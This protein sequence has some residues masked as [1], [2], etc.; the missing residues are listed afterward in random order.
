MKSGKRHKQTAPRRKVRFPISAKILLCLGLNIAV[1]ALVFGW[2][3]RSHFG[4]EQDWL[5]NNTARERLQAMNLVLIAELRESPLEDWDEIIRKAGDAHRVKL[6]LFEKSGFHVAGC[7]VTLPPELSER[8][9]GHGTPGRSQPRKSR[10]RKQASD[11]GTGVFR[12]FGF[13][14]DEQKAELER[15]HWD[16]VERV[17][18]IFE[19]SEEGRDYLENG[20]RQWDPDPDRKRRFI[21]DTLA[22]TRSERYGPANYIKEAV[23]SKD[24]EGYWFMV[25]LPYVY[26]SWLVLVGHAETLGG[27]GLLFNPRP[28]LLATGAVF[29]FSLLLWFPVARSI[30][31]SVSRVTVAAEEIAQGNFEARIHNRRSDEL[32]VL[33]ESINQMAGRLQ[34][35]VEGQKRFLGDVAHE[36]CSPLARMELGL[37]ILEQKLGEREVEQVTEVRQ[38]LAMMQSLVDELLAFTRAGLK[39]SEPLRE[40][41]SVEAILHEALEQEAVGWTSNLSIEGEPLAL[42][43]PR[44]LRRALANIIRNARQHAGEDAP[45]EVAVKQSGASVRITIADRGPGVAP[46]SLP[47]LFEPFFR[48]DTSRA[49]ETGGAGLGMAIVWNCIQA[50]GGEVAAHNREGGGLLIEI[51]LQAGAR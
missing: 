11:E 29:A 19:Q 13:L 25:R 42:A 39:G 40:S 26:P 43:D 45:L 28:W 7:R 22:R 14:S 21:H 41:V 31:R 48:E 18:R 49:R 5:L 51:T 1:I 15:L 27:T 37:G 33:S 35:Y 3:L 9:Q 44:L 4:M 12:P 8:L 36:L 6:A 32:G 20:R 17:R 47:R 50:C 23:R 16:H 2:L 34:G 38:E 10:W 46:E 24:P 30:T